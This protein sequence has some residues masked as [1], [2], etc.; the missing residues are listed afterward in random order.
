MRQLKNMLLR[1]LEGRVVELTKEIR[2]NG[3]KVFPS[4][5]RMVIVDKRRGLAL[6]YLET[7]RRMEIRRVSY[8]CVILIADETYTLPSAA[9]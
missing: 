2:N 5:M 3:G 4:G 6:A 8:D 1:E 9:A 7:P